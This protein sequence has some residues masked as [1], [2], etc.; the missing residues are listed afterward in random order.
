M[1][2][3]TISCLLHDAMLKAQ[4]NE[5]PLKPRVRRAGN[6]SAVAPAAAS[7]STAVAA[8]SVREMEREGV[9][10]RVCVCELE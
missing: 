3:A 4:R 2:C 6:N 9:C 5:F 7:A 8:V 10:L 1:D